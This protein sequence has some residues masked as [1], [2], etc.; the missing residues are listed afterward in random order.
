MLYWE[1]SFPL[2]FCENSMICYDTKT[3]SKDLTI[4]FPPKYFADNARAYWDP[5]I[6]KKA[7]S[8]IAEDI[9]LHV[10]YLPQVEVSYFPIHFQSKG[11]GKRILM[12]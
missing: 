1:P 9:Y 6:A 2:Y 10:V 8:I 3:Q 4:L 5:H 11:R 7:K 12:I